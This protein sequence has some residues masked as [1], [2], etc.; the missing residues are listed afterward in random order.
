MK[1]GRVTYTVNRKGYHL[2]IDDVRAWVCT[3][4]GEPFYEGDTIEA[5]QEA[6]QEMEGPLQ[7]VQQAAA[8]A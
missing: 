8:T 3:Q 6:V 2:L 7:K 1:E 4:C 5:I